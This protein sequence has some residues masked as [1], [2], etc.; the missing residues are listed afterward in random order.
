MTEEKKHEVFAF[1]K[2]NS[3]LKDLP[4]DPDKMYVNN[5]TLNYMVDLY[6]FRRIHAVE[7][8]SEK[9]LTLCDDILAGLS[10]MQGEELYFVSYNDDLVSV[11][12]LVDEVM[13][14]IYLFPVS[15]ANDGYKT[16]Q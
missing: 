16:E 8:K 2:Q 9:A 3:I 15:G 5:T 13:K 12:G 1:F 7:R 14:H 10:Y 11:Y 4:I 6:Q